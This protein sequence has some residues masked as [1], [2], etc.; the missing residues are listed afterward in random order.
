MAENM[1]S[2]ISNLLFER[3]MTQK[4]LAIAANIT[5]SA[6]SHY[7]KGDRVPRGVNLAKVARA[8]ETTTDY[9]LGQD[10]VSNNKNDIKSAITIIARDAAKM[11][12]EERDELIEILSSED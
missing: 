1:A 3:D 8:L 10:D 6:I 7:V 9:L 4:E 12:K 11:T 5:E 2:R